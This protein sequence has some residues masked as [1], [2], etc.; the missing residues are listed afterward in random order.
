[1]N[2][3]EELLLKITEVQS[4]TE[5]QSN[6]TLKT[7]LQ[8]EVKSFVKESLSNK[9]GKKL[10]KEEDEN[11][12]DYKE[13]IVGGDE[14][15]MDI[16]A[17][18]D[19]DSEDD[20]MIPDLDVSPVSDDVDYDED[21]NVLDLTSA[22]LEEVL[23]KLKDLP[24]DTVIEIVKNPA[25]FNVKP[26][27]NLNEEEC[28]EDEDNLTEGGYSSWNDYDGDDRDDDDTDSRRENMQK[29]FGDEDVDSNDE[30]YLE[31]KGF[32]I[33]E[34]NGFFGI[35][36]MSGEVIVEPNYTF[37]SDMMSGH[38]GIVTAKD[39]NGNKTKIDIYSH[40]DNSDN[41]SENELDEW[42][43]EALQENVK[44]KLLK[45]YE[46]IIEQYE[47]KLKT[48][49]KKHSREMNQMNEQLTAKQGESKSLKEQQLKY[50]SALKKSNQL[51]EQL[52]VH[53]TNLLHI[54]KLFTEQTVSRE[55]KIQIAT[56]FDGVKTVNE[57]KILFEALNQTLPKKSLSQK[58][59]VQQL[60]EEMVS[61]TA[62]KEILKEEKTFKDPDF[63]RF[64]K[65][66]GYKI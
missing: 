37:I 39:K 40:M 38:N 31:D 65:L 59:N 9:K 62:K 30:I 53:N 50:N 64:N 3:L 43:A 49:N 34:E 24:D 60:K 19:M 27:N 26:S 66:V 33:F 23:A 32:D 41:D 6:E 22:S 4:L 48:L 1:M 29:R 17:T 14:D 42:I 8:T 10:I 55:E 58:K 57:S 44:T 25:T 56:Q 20:E 5:A 21:E 35:Q 2:N 61:N 7:V 46:L 12:P 11:E 47:N 54:T 36:D 16:D 45:E 15:D 52:A 18:S 13:E 51:L 63:E 28:D